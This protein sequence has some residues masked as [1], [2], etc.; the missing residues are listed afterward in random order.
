[1][2]IFSQES[3]NMVCYD[4]NRIKWASRNA[5]PVFGYPRYDDFIR[6]K[7]AELMPAYFGNCHESKVKKWME[8]GKS[9]KV[10]K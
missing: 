7:I 5:A 9:T 10:N 2:N 3:I 8:T 6:L 4:S 1:M